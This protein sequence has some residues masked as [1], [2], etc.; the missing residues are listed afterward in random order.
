MSGN[1]LFCC[2]LFRSAAASSLLLGVYSIYN[3]VVAPCLA[4]TEK[5]FRYEKGFP[6]MLWSSPPKGSTTL[7]PPKGISASG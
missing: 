1:P 6:D 7:Y 5:K 4:R 2:N 3:L